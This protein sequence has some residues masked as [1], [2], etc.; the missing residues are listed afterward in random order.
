MP[1]V[2]NPPLSRLLQ[3][4]H[5][6]LVPNLLVCS[7]GTEILHMDDGERKPDER[8][9]KILDSGWD[10]AAVLEVAEQFNSQMTLQV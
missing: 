7:V 4:A 5:P 9:E 1:I 3:A 2:D 10:R 6:L 8:W